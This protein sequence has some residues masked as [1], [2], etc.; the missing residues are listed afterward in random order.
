MKGVRAGT[1]EEAT[2]TPGADGPVVAFA[3][4]RQ[5]EAQGGDVTWLRVFSGSAQVRRQ[6]QL[7]R[8]PQQRAHG[9]AERGRGQ[10]QGEDRCGRGRRHRPGRQAEEHPDRGRP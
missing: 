3:F 9:P 8:R 7:Q 10:E 6:P 4:K 1:E 2:F 5:Y